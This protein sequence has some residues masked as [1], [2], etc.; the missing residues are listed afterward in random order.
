MPCCPPL[1]G[2]VKNVLT[3]KSCGTLGATIE[4]V[5]AHLGQWG[6]DAAAH[7]RKR[8]DDARE[9]LLVMARTAESVGERDQRCARQF[10]EVT[11]QLKTIADLND[12]TKIRV[13]LK[14]SASELKAS[15][16]RMTAE[17]EAAVTELRVQVST[18]QAQLEQAEQVANRDSL[19]HLQSRLS[20]EREGER[21]I[22]SGARFCAAILDIDGFKRVNDEHGH[23]VGDE[24]LK[25]FADEL[26]R[27]CRNSDVI[28]RWGGD[29]FILL[30]D[31]G[32]AEAQA[33]IERTREWFC[34]NYTIAGSRGT[35]N[36]RVD[37]SIGVAEVR[38]GEA[39]KQLLDR[40]DADMY[41]N[42]AGARSSRR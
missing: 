35:L 6:A 22:Q 11:E 13:S 37:V 25:Q 36:L 32:L 15:I 12:L 21:R 39:L 16:D 3:S 42:K 1:T 5:C 40:A 29:E 41:Q 7:Y 8:A 18:Y 4:K 27:T 14:K 9:M 20:V 31:C 2:L 24:L 10:H 23:L 19:T 34:G 30:L 17:G 28:G 33:R 26:R 38:P